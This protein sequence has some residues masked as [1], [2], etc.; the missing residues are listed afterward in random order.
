MKTTQQTK[1]K[2]SNRRTLKRVRNKAILHCTAS[3]SIGNRYMS[4]N[5]RPADP[6]PSAVFPVKQNTDRF[7]CRGWS[8]LS[9][10]LE[11]IDCKYVSSLRMSQKNP[12]AKRLVCT[13]EHNKTRMWVIATSPVIQRTR[14]TTTSRGT[15]S[16]CR[17]TTRLKL[18]STSSL[19]Q[20]TER[21][22]NTEEY[23]SMGNGVSPRQ[24]TGSGD[25]YPSSS[26][27][28][29]ILDIPVRRYQLGRCSSGR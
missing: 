7:R 14:T 10:T 17:Y 12:A 21:R 22:L 26:K 4:T 8:T 6:A 15:Y 9:T 25:A 20:K 2:L 19:T 24:N 11:N 29:P 18:S 28:Q 5:C 23:L 3:V 1:C 27:S 13:V 16:R